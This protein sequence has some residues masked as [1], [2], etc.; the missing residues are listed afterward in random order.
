MF[1]EFNALLISSR[2]TLW[3]PAVVGHFINGDNKM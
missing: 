1:H 3:L 2:I